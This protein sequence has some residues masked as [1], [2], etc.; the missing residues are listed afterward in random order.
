MDVKVNGKQLVNFKKKMDCRNHKNLVV[1]R[2]YLISRS[3]YFY[4]FSKYF[5]LIK[6]GKQF[7]TSN[8]SKAF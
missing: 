8:L 5:V 7:Q 3:S 2:N 1:K 4:T 6:N